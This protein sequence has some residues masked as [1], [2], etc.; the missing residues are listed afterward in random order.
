M[1]L[2]GQ[3]VSVNLSIARGQEW[4]IGCLQVK[5]HV[6][7]WSSADSG[8]SHIIQ[9]GASLLYTLTRK[10]SAEV[11]VS[12]LLQAQTVI[13]C[14]ELL[15]EAQPEARRLTTVLS[16]LGKHEGLRSFKQTF[17][18]AVQL[19]RVELFHWNTYI[20]VVGRRGDLL[21]AFRAFERMRQHNTEPDVFT[22][23]ALLNACIRAGNI[24]EAMKVYDRL[25]VS[26]TPTSSM[27]NVIHHAIRKRESDSIIIS[28]TEL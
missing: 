24:H 5:L 26:W 28:D 7:W 14:C 19:G 9:K 11:I 13:R 27:I 4:A 15:Q 6:R 25:K 12:K 1:M 3:L 8:C 20:G 10:S 18:A 21:E 22:F 17:E 23:T 2:T 16:K